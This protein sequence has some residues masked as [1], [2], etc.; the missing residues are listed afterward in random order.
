M[1]LLTLHLP[2]FIFLSSNKIANN[3]TTHAIPNSYIKLSLAHILKYNLDPYI[4]VVNHLFKIMVLLIFLKCLSLHFF[5]YTFHY[6][7]R[8]TSLGLAF[9]FINH[10]DSDLYSHKNLKII[11][12]SNHINPS[13]SLFITLSSLAL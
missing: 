2:K 3:I 6:K 7:L 5:K 4:L 8:C 10:N 9:P 1:L 12:S 11:Y 13:L